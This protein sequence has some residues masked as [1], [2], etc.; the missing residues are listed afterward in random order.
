MTTTSPGS[1]SPHGW[2]WCRGDRRRAPPRHPG[3]AVAAGVGQRTGE[4]LGPIGGQVRHDLRSGTFLIRGLLTYADI[5]TDLGFD[6][7]LEA[8]LSR[9]SRE[10][11]DPLL[12]LRSWGIPVQ[13]GLAEG[14]PRALS[15]LSGAARVP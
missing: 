3:A 7:R 6:D 11:A 1:A 10:W 13:P 14:Q 9:P 2:S 15:A 8:S 12:E 5:D 4:T